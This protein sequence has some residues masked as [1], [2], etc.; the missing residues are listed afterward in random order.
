MLLGRYIQLITAITKCAGLRFMNHKIELHD[1]SR[2]F[3]Q[4]FEPDTTAETELG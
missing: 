4:A 2:S 1:P 3:K